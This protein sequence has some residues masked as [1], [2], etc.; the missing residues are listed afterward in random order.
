MWR[1]GLAAVLTL[2]V[3]IRHG[4][5]QEQKPLSDETA[6]TP[7]FTL[8]EQSS[9]LCDA[10]SRQWTGTVNVTTEKSMFFCMHMLNGSNL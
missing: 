8:R 9:D 3:L 7:L 4:V 10:G 5:S 2:S 6:N 1:A